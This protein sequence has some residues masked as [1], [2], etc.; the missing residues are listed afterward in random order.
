MMTR[1][2]AEV[3]LKKIVLSEPCKYNNFMKDLTDLVLWSGS[4]VKEVKESV[5]TE[6]CLSKAFE[7]D[8]RGLLTQFVRYTSWSIS[9]NSIC[10][11]KEQTEER[12]REISNFVDKF[13][14]K[15][16]DEGQLSNDVFLNEKLP[17]YEG[18]SL[19]D[20]FGFI[21]ISKTINGLSNTLPRI[22]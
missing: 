13:L 1:R 12:L 10:Q 7:Y 5:I 3:F 22:V 20:S 18:E 11:P 2:Q 8:Y 4:I 14:D 19:N 21:Q 16:V 17:V 9:C 15:L 6:L